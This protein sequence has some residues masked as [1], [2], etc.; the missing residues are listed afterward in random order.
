MG[1]TFFLHSGSLRAL[2]DKPPDPLFSKLALSSGD[3]PEAFLPELFPP[4]GSKAFRRNKSDHRT[5]GSCPA[6]FRI[7]SSKYPSPARA[8]SFS[9]TGS[10]LEPGQR[11][12]SSLYSQL[13]NTARLYIRPLGWEEKISLS[14]A[15]FHTV[16]S[17]TSGPFCRSPFLLRSLSR[18]VRMTLYKSF[19]PGLFPLP[20]YQK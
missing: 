3:E 18:V 15:E 6:I 1:N 2:P 17:C 19:Y 4:T 7:S 5:M 20:Q 14:V 9:N 8:F 11:L 13:P 10:A 16:D 12:F